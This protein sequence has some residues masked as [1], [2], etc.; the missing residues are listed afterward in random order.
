MSEVNNA[1]SYTFQPHAI[2]LTIGG[3]DPS[4]GAGIQADLKTFQQLGV[5]GASAVT[6]ITV[7]NTQLVDRVEMLSPKLVV[8][9]INAIVSDLDVAVAKTGALGNAS[10]IEAVTERA[11]EFEFPLVVDPVMISK[12]GTFIVEDDA[13]KAYRELLKHA[14][15]VTPNRFELQELTG[16]ELVD[17]NAIARAIHDLHELGARYVLVKMGEKNG[18]SH[19]IFGDGQQ[20]LAINVNRF[21]TQHT[22]GAG[23]V[24]SSAIAGLLAL[25]HNNLLDV[26]HQ[27][28]ELVLIGI[29][30]AH[31]IGKGRCPVE[32]RVLRR[33]LSST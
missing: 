33:K 13:V 14:L 2:A 10:I 28:I 20:N 24:L 6:L 5:Y 25:G 11:S 27:A 12:H 7:Q 23:C 19:H 9:Q 15:L 32:T 4:G 18:D 17:E 16:I 30:N 26:I 22:H 29:Y 3:S 21:D 1:G 8:D 31:E